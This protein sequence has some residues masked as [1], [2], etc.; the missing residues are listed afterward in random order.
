MNKLPQNEI[1]IVEMSENIKI[2]VTS[3][4]KKEQA[5][6]MG[7]V[8]ISHAYMSYSTNRLSDKISKIKKLISLGALFSYGTGWSPSELMSYYIQQG[9]NFD[10]FKVIA[11]SNTST[12]HIIE[13]DPNKSTK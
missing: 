8:E 7:F 6:Q 4:E 3:I 10:K 11:W 5:S 9:Y 12:Y 1:I 13:Y 2:L